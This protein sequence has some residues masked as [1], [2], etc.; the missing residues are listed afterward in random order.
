MVQAESDDRDGVVAL[1]QHGKHLL[2]VGIA[3]ET[4]GVELYLPDL[5]VEH[6][7]YAHAGT[8][9]QIEGD[10]VQRDADRAPAERFI[11]VIGIIGRGLG[12]LRLEPGAKA[13]IVLVEML[14]QQREPEYARGEEREDH[15]RTAPDPAG[16]QKPYHQTR[17][18]LTTRGGA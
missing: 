15:R 5:V 1:F 3:F 14:H 7:R 13:R 9:R 12:R 11:G 2:L 18:K 6:E 4:A 10:T 17:P 16:K 8:T